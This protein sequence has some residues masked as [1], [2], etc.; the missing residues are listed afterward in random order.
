M[1]RIVNGNDVLDDPR[2]FADILEQTKHL[3][4]D[5]QSRSA[6]V[7]TIAKGVLGCPPLAL[8]AAGWLAR[9]LW[10]ARLDLVRARSHR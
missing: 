1:S 4:L 10:R 5:R 8:R 3:Q 9:K 2:L 7:A 6:A